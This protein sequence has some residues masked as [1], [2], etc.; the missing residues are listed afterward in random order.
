M[1]CPSCDSPYGLYVS[2]RKKNAMNLYKLS[3]KDCNFITNKW[4]DE[5]SPDS[6]MFV[7]YNFGINPYD[8]WGPDEYPERFKES[9]FS[10]EKEMKEFEE[11]YQVILVE[12]K[13][14]WKNYNDE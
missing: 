9:N 13:P 3:C 14:Q 5:T 11:S 12:D 2:H 8:E 4:I 6:C 7:F 10:T 1:T